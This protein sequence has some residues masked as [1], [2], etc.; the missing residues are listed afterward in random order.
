MQKTG[1]DKNGGSGRWKKAL[2]ALSL[3]LNLAIAGV[4][5]GTFLRSGGEERRLSRSPG[6]GAFGAP[7]MLAL[8]KEDRRSVFASMRAGKDERM[9][10]RRMRR[11]MFANVLENLRATPFDPA[12]LEAAVSKQAQSSVKVQNRVQKAW[13]D[14]V[15]KMNDEERAAYAA[16]VEQYLSRGKKRR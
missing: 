3:A 12:A 8:D 2:L 10:D 11:E 4:V 16:S 7:Y 1:H 5:V 9:P 14:V 6:Q 15:S 13:L